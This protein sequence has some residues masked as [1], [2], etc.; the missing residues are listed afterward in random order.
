[1]SIDATTEI[2]GQGYRLIK[3]DPLRGGRMATRVAQQLAGA[4]DDAD[5]I[6]GLI[7][8][9]QG[10]REEE[11][12]TASDAEEKTKEEKAIDALMSSPGILS[13]L[14]GGVSKVNAD[15]LYDCALECIRGNLF[16]DRKLHD[17]AA[18]NA[19]FAQ[20]PDHL[21]LVLA[22]ALKVNCSGFFGFGGAD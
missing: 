15:G 21:L 5:A 16:A 10:K 20:K 1:M 13:A 8:L 9:Y 3:L 7:E 12:A 6:K 19:W 4:I 11:Q 14:A 22:W 17:D 18:I 2:K